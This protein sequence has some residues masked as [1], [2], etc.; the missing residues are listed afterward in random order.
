MQATVVHDGGV[1]QDQTCRQ[2]RL[3]FKSAP[4]TWLEATRAS[5]GDAESEWKALP[6][7]EQR[8]IKA[9]ADAAAGD[10]IL[11]ARIQ[12]TSGSVAAQRARRSL[13]P[14]RT[15]ARTC[16]HAGREGSSTLSKEL[17]GNKYVE[18]KKTRARQTEETKNAYNY[19]TNKTVIRVAVKIMCWKDCTEYDIEPEF[20]RLYHPSLK[21]RGL[22]RT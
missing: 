9:V 17:F 1:G 12:R 2:K 11:H 22:S 5:G 7:S 4:A 8:A 10:D 15:H 21:C 6:S 14:H 13:S 20:A 16:T 3:P 18:K 19:T